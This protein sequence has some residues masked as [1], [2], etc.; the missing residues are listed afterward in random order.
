M[1]IRFRPKRA[2]DFSELPQWI[3]RVN[4]GDKEQ[5]ETKDRSREVAR[6]QAEADKQN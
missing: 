6:L 2:M 4:E 5:L 3:F 1:A